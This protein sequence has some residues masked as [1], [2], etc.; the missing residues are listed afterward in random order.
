M[1]TA[2]LHAPLDEKVYLRQLKGL[3]TGN[4]HDIWELFKALYGL[5]QAPRAWNK[6]L[7][8]KLIAAGWVQSDA[9]PSLCL[10]YN[11][12]NEVIAAALIYVDDLQLAS[13][14]PALVDALI[15]EIKGWWPCTV[16]AA[17]RFLGIEIHHDCYTFI[18]LDLNN[19][20]FT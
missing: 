4:A 5:K 10:Q 19:V 1:S 18:K 14:D 7:S 12:E 6:L 3:R 20:F 16:Q 9:D 11:S 17:D 13:K 2:F 15:A 8:S